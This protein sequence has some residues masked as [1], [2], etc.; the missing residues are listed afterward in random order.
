VFS[1]A[2]PPDYLEKSTLIKTL[3]NIELRALSPI[4]I[5]VTK[6]GRLDE[7]DVDDIKACITEYKLKKKDIV[8]R[9]KSVQVAGNESVYEYNL[10]SAMREF[11]PKSER[12]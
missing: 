11:F 7:R 5:V 6:I 12:P 4:D 1:Q 2:L 8:S 3:K 9:A 10:D